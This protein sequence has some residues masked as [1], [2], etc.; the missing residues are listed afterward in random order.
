MVWLGGPAV[1]L[2]VAVWLG[3]HEG[4]AQVW[5]ALPRHMQWPCRT[6][7]THSK[8]DA[9]YLSTAFGLPALACLCRR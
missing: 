9:D 6:A 4:A 8:A 3:G 5:A 7:R 1:W 2:S